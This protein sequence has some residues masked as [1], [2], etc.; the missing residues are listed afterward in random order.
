M[1]ADRSEPA[2]RCSS[3]GCPGHSSPHLL[4]IPTRTTGQLAAVTGAGQIPVDVRDVWATESVED[5]TYEDAAIKAAYRAGVAAGRTQV[6]E[7]IAAPALV[8]LVTRAIAEALCECEP[9]FPCTMHARAAEAAVSA[10]AAAGQLLPA[11][12]LGID[13]ERT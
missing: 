13:L 2:R 1:D 3:P 10:L 12:G 5:P 4:C 8:Q 6:A 7:D 11:R 9:E